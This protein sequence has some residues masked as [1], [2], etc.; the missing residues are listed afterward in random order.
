MSERG[1]ALLASLER[2][3]SPS[4]MWCVEGYE[5]EHWE[6]YMTEG[7]KVKYVSLG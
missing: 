1:R 7:G 6:I 2:D 3:L 5:A 4:V